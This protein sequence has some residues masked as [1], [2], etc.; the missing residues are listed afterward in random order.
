MANNFG[1]LNNYGMEY[2]DEFSRKPGFFSELGKQIGRDNSSPLNQLY[3]SKITPQQAEQA[4]KGAIGNGVKGVG[5]K[6]LFGGL[7]RFAG[8]IGTAFGIGELIKAY[9]DLLPPVGMYHTIQD[10]YNQFNG[11]NKK[12]TFD[13]EDENISSKE[14]EE[15]KQVQNKQQDNNY[16]MYDIINDLQRIQNIDNNNQIPD[17][18]NSQEPLQGN[19][20]YNDEDIDEL[21]KQYTDLLQ[22]KNQPYIQAIERY[23]NNYDK[24]LNQ[25]RRADLYFYGANLAKGLNPKAGEKFN[26]L[27]NQMDIINTIK[28]LQDARYENIGEINKMRGAM[29]IAKQSGLSPR[30]AFADKN[31]I[32]SYLINRRYNDIYNSKEDIARLN[33]LSKRDLALIR[34]KQAIDAQNLRNMGGLTNAMVYTAPQYNNAQEALQTLIDLGI[35]IPNVDYEPKEPVNSNSKSKTGMDYDR[36]KK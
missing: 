11:G 4:I 5:A 18:N 35:P 17:I 25:A 20:N 28:A 27:Q 23:L 36:Y 30:S 16:N 22:K 13:M 19:V 6:S 9:P 31:L 10:L 2:I 1:N 12:E 21:L 24:N 33:N 14:T 32:N 29:E 3:K 7:G 8:P 15:N 26:P 34:Y